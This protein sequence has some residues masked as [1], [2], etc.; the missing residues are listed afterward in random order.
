M[1]SVASRSR[2]ARGSVALVGHQV[3][4]LVPVLGL[5]LVAAAIETLHEGFRTL[6]SGHL[7]DYVQAQGP[8]G[9]HAVNVSRVAPTSALTDGDT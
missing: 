1:L 2:R 6:S 3:S 9:L 4:W 5:S 8:R 7:V